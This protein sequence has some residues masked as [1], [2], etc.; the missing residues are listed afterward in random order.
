[1][2]NEISRASFYFN[3]YPFS[4]INPFKIIAMFKRPF[5]II[6]FKFLI[7]SFDI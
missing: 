5:K 7:I 4:F 6:E 1:M 2:T 3:D